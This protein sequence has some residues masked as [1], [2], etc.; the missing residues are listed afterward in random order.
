ML[1]SAECAAIVLTF[2]THN[3]LALSVQKFLVSFLSHAT[4]SKVTNQ[5]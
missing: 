3:S 5:D 1:N 4:F 2:E